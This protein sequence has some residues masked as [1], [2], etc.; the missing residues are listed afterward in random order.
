MVVKVKTAIDTHKNIT[1]LY[2]ELS[3]MASSG[4]LLESIGSS[5]Q[6]NNLTSQLRT[7]TVLLFQAAANVFR[8][9]RCKVRLFFE[10]GEGEGNSSRKRC[11]CH[12]LF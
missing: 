3:K 4:S 6:L 10:E 12:L 11:K 1:T 5:V 8:I 2:N 7:F 9:V